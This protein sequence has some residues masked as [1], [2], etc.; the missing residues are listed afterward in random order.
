VQKNNPSEHS[1]DT[2]TN[3]VTERFLN[4]APKLFGK[5]PALL[6]TDDVL[7]LIAAVLFL[8]DLPALLE[9]LAK[10]L[11]ARDPHM[12]DLERERNSREAQR[13][14]INIFTKTLLPG[15]SSKGRKSKHHARDKEIFKLRQ[16]GLSFGEIGKRL[17]ISDKVAQSACKRYA[18]IVG[19]LQ[20]LSGINAILK[21]V[22]ALA[23]SQ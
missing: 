17:G 15:K 22:E 20:I 3:E 16:S 19:D 6:T 4:V 23:A 5:H 14:L 10:L 13:I 9:L 8:R 11:R 2:L 1:A 7:N 21:E 18:Q 12:S